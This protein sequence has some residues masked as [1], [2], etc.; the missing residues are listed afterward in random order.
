[1]PEKCETTIR[2]VLSGLPITPSRRVRP[3]LT[4]ELLCDW[5]AS[6]H[7]GEAIVYHEGFLTLDRS[8]AESALP[9]RER[10]RVHALA[11][12]AWI[13]SELGL[14]RL[15]SQRVGDGHYRYLAVR[16]SSRLTPPDIRHRL[17]SAKSLHSSTH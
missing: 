15:F 13:A 9:E 3:V 4:E 14:L 2:E 17:R 1:M 10:A 6:A 12:R 8:A 11:R 5:I 16:A 7:A